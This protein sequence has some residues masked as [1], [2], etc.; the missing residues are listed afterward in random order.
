MKWK[1]YS[2]ENCPPE[3]KRVLISDGEIITIAHWSKDGENRIWFFENTNFKDLKIVWWK[4][5][6]SL[7]PI[8]TAFNDSKLQTDI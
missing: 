4:N 6:P 1:S 7:P 3:S 2:Q 8:L 5:L